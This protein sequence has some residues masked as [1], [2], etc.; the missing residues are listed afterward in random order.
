MEA[1]V[2]PSP[3]PIAAT[4]HAADCHAGAFDAD[5]GCGHTTLADRLA[6]LLADAA[7]EAAVLRDADTL[8]L[9]AHDVRRAGA[10]PLLVFRP[11]DVAALQ[12]GLAAIAATG[13]S[14]V[15][16]GGGMS[17][18]DGIIC[19]RRDTIAVDLARLDRV[20]R[21]D[22][23]NL[24][25]TVE[26]G[27]TWARLDEALAPHG[28]RTPF[29]GPMSGRFA[30]VGG[31][32]AQGTASFGTAQVGTSGDNLLGLEVVLADG[33]LL[34]T[35]P[36]GQPGTLPFL[37][38]YGPDLAGLFANDCGA[39]GI[40]ARI[41][42][43]LQPRPGAVDHL[44]LLFADF[45]TMAAAMQAIA[46][47]GL[48]S[49]LFAMDPVVTRQFAGASIGF[50]QD[51]A[52]LLAIG[53]AEPGPLSAALRMAQVARAG[54]R[55]IGREGFQ[56]HAIFEGRSARA[57]RERKAQARALAAGSVELPPTIPA[58]LRA[59]PF[60]PLPLLAPDGQ[61]VLPIHGILPWS[62]AVAFDRALA[63]LL[64]ATAGRCAAARLTVA[65]SFFAIAR[66]ALL[67]EPV[68]YWADAPT[69]YQAARSPGIEARHP[70]NPQARALV[71]ELTTR[72]IR[73]LRDHGATHLQIGRVYPFAEGR[74]EPALGLLRAIKRNLDPQGRMNP[75]VLGL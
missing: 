30:T 51:L 45:A 8:M 36:A 66:S 11:A 41:T 46:R 22:T 32:L 20:T 48:A 14:L 61:R 21:I 52:M 57:A 28:L 60:P 74:N 29:W 6:E 47:E 43:P 40:K 35:G 53:R 34:V 5:P 65:G 10:P 31:A 73:L 13:V 9:F 18:T 62:A 63:A 26:A 4:D 70:D 38:Q 49:E 71:D 42:L 17:Y 75:G 59:A 39:L 25:V 56:L 58:A 54:R 50:R 64:K 27:C 1:P 24:F 19:D 37:R 44:S 23:A 72:I 55:F 2:T 33:R 7:G 16:R 3:P 69:P 68:F 15:P 12:A 67:Y